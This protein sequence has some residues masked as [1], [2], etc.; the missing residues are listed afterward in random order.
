MA[1][2]SLDR[3]L[4]ARIVQAHSPQQQAHWWAVK[5]AAK[6]FLAAVPPKDVDWQASRV[7]AI[8]QGSVEAHR[9]A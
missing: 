8:L 7:L 1:V 9:A 3:Y 2:Q 5:I 4:N 6:R